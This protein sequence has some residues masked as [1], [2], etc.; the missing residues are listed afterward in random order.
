MTPPT[1]TARR[2]LQR[3]DDERLAKL[4]AADRTGAFA[5]LYARHHQA[6]YRYC[7]TIVRDDA[8]AQDALQATWLRALTALRRGR[9]D[10]PLRPWL[11]RIAHNESIS[12]LRRR[13][14]GREPVLLAVG[15]SCSAEEEVIARER[16]TQLLDDL[17][18]L[19]ERARSAL[20]LR[21][22]T[23]LSHEE[24]A[25]SL[26]ITVAAAK[27]SVYEARRGLQ[28]Q[29]HGRALGCGEI[30][31]RLSDGDRRV[32]R[33]RVVRAHVRHCARCAA[34][35]ASIEDRR[36][37]LE[38]VTPSLG[39][40]ATG[41]VLARVLGGGG[42]SGG[43]GTLG[44]SAGGGAASAGAGKA[45]GVGLLAKSLATVGVAVT[46]A[47][48]TVAVVAGA[49]H[50]Q[51]VA[52]RAPQAAPVRVPQP[53][54]DANVAA[55]SLPAVAR[56]VSRA[57]SDRVI[58]R[59]SVPAPVQRHPHHAP[60]ALIVLGRRASAHAAARRP[61]RV[62]A[63]STRGSGAA[64]HL[65]R[66][67]GSTARPAHGRAVATHWTHR[68]AASTHVTHRHAA[69]THG[70]PGGVTRTLA[71]HRRAARTGT[72]RH[73]ART[74]RAGGPGGGTVPAAGGTGVVSGA[75]AGSGRH[76]AVADAARPRRAGP[77]SGGI[78]R[79][80][81]ASPGRP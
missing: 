10:A 58:L 16:F 46:A 11:F 66:G 18:V 68:H 78:G 72:S 1:A 50:T 20:V 31:R 51:H 47:G 57:S 6:L 61:P 60:A 23:G 62:P 24:I 81:S 71:V 42:G 4:S 26:Q 35:A 56:A 37:V 39:L 12:I 9:R 13:A 52:D 38:A 25:R 76:G 65:P 27:Q 53:A 43:A 48:V 33:G 36:Q 28:E 17:R 77:G 34:F 59:R 40:L 2:A 73:E 41:G 69:A 7:L 79:D 14:R 63:S 80:R 75:A 64:H 32:L 44:A 3:L 29:T 22:L 8:D 74:M 15:A 55:A 49:P 45:I 54:A 70:G 5:A 30:Q 67:P 19:P 21:E